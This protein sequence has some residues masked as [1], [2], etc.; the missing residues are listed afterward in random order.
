MSR[1]GFSWKRLLGIS[2]FKSRVS[3]KIGIPLT[4]SG[5]RRKLG[6][7]IFNAA[8][9]MAGTAAVA[10]VAAGSRQLRQPRTDTPPAQSPQFKSVHL[11]EV[12][13]VTHQNEDGTSRRAAQQ[14]CSIGDAVNLIPESSNFHDQ[15]AI[16]VMLQS[17]EQIGYLSARQAA[18][19]EGKVHLLSATVH[20]RVKDQWGNDTVKLRVVESAESNQAV[21]PNTEQLPNLLAAVQ[22]EGEEEAAK[23][24]WHTVFLYSEKENQYCVSKMNSDET[25]QTLQDGFAP[26]GFIGLKSKPA[27][28]NPD[29]TEALFDFS[30]RDGIPVGSASAKRLLTNGQRWAVTRCNEISSE[31]GAPPPTVRGTN[32]NNQ[33]LHAQKKS[34]AIGLTIVVAFV[35]LVLGLV[36]GAWEVTTAI[37]VLLWLILF[38]ATRPSSN[39]M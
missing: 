11:C 27:T 1:G 35:G 6:G 9:S 3:R 7:A 25:R 22:R 38:L 30:L 18:R 16:R 26:I 31:H 24:G 23:E 2:A 17:G 34:H 4:A 28:M 21:A 15:H 5:R 36:T 10:A 13:G 32:C 29:H 14:L 33:F 20:S 39:R 37:S 12:K 19:F 8:G